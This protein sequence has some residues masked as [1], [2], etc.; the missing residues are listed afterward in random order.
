MSEPR[1]RKCCIDSRFRYRWN[2]RGK[3]EGGKKGRR[4]GGMYHVPDDERRI[5]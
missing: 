4:G 5:L 2:L 1:D 3:C